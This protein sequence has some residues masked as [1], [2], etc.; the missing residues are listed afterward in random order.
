[1]Y[2]SVSRFM[3][4]FLWK[5][6][7]WKLL[8]HTATSIGAALAGRGAALAVVHRVVGA[9]GCAALARVGA[10]R[11]HRI[12]VFIAPRDRCCGKA[13]NIGTLHVQCDAASH[14]FRVLLLET[15]GSAL[16]AGCRTIVALA[17]ALYFALIQHLVLL[18]G[19]N[20]Q[21]FIISAPA[22]AGQCAR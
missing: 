8:G 17:K 13:A 21:G 18:D 4:F 5:G 11:A 9:L 22:L 14:R 7:V 19:L 20:V 2:L 16:K 1:M 3:V 10:K 6:R 12:H 15:G